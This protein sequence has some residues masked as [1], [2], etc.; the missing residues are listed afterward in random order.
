MFSLNTI[1]FQGI[2][3]DYRNAVVA[4]V[5][6]SLQ[7]AYPDDLAERV[8]A[9]FKQEWDKTRANALSSRNSGQYGAQLKDDCDL[10]GVNHFYNLFEKYFDILFPRVKEH[11]ETDRK[12]LKRSVLDW[13]GNIKVMR[14]PA[15]GHPRRRRYF[16]T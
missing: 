14:D 11:S 8:S 2:C 1:C 10:L 16:G 9:P 12:A 4:H 5:R 7:A 13:A 15:T 6:A 3:R